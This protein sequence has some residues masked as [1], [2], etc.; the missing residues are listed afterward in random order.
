[1]TF[2]LFV[3]PVL[4]ALG[5]ERGYAPRFAEA[6]LGEAVSAKPGLRRFLPARLTA[7]SNSVVVTLVPWQGSG[8]VSGT[9]QANC[10]LVVP[11][12]SPGSSET[13]ASGSSVRVLLLT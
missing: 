10:L 11:E 13:V 6:R 12:L 7:D 8:D 4:A 1:V 2:A 3:A 5:G 9:A